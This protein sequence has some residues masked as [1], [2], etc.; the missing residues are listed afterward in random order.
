[1]IVRGVG[2]PQSWRRRASSGLF[3]CALALQAASLIAATDARAETLSDAIRRALSVNPTLRS[4]REKLTATREKLPQAA[5]G[6]LPKVSASADYGRDVTRVS[7][8][9]SID[10]NLTSDGSLGLTPNPAEQSTYKS[11]P[12]SYGVQATQT[13]FDGGRTFAAMS[14]ARATISSESQTTRAAEQDTILRTVSAFTDLIRWNE[15]VDSRRESEAFLARQMHIMQGRHRFG[16]VTGSD[17]ALVSARLADARYRLAEGESARHQARAVYLQVTGAAPERPAPPAPLDRTLPASLDEAAAL[18]MRSNPRLLSSDFAIG[19]A[20]AQVKI[21]E[22]DFLPTVSVTGGVSRRSDIQTPGDRVDRAYVMGKLTVPIFDGGAVLSRT[23]ESVATLAQKRSERD[24]VR[25]SVRSAL[26]AAWS[27]WEAAKIQ[28]RAAEM[29]VAFAG[30][31][32]SAMLE[33]YRIG[34]RSFSEVLLAQGDLAQARE[35]AASARRDR[36]LSSF[37][38]AHAIGALEARAMPDRLRSEPQVSAPAPRSGAEAVRH[39]QPSDDDW[40]L[41]LGQAG[42]APVAPDGA[43]D[44]LLKA[45]LRR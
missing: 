1:M 4:Q 8:P 10:Y 13:L 45:S 30:K 6:L 39:G 32:S 35:N 43:I 40:G 17:V 28:A 26:V 38:V 31:A 18:A 42:P 33:Q 22:A 37:G 34:E 29:Q 2:Q 44:R 14:G 3:V 16:D 9:S 36:V 7:T 27:N 25:D 21:A 24:A 41:R 20:R 19:A 15:V 23:R 12:K 11:F 5:S